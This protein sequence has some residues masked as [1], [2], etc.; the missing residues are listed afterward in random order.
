MQSLKERL[1]G[2]DPEKIFQFR[3]ER[4]KEEMQEAEKKRKE[5]YKEMKDYFGQNLFWIFFK[6]YGTEEKV[7]KAL[8]ITKQK[9]KDYKYFLGI[10]LK[11]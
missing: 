11:S 2:K 7:A 10:L 1:Q 6:P 8:S 4:H 3:R 9:K 5:L